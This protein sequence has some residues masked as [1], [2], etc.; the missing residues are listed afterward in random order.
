MEEKDDFAERLLACLKKEGYIILTQKQ[1]DEKIELAI[2]MTC[3]KLG[4]R[5]EK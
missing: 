2:K 3:E 4:V 5:I 1:L